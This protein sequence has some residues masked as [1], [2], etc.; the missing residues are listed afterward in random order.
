MSAD[1]TT[2]PMAATTDGVINHALNKSIA[3]RNSHAITG[4]NQSDSGIFGA[5]GKFLAA[6]GSTED[7]PIHVR[8]IPP[9]GSSGLHTVKLVTTRRRL[10][11]DYDTQHGLL[12][13]NETHGLYF[14]VN[15]G[16]DSG[17]D[18]TRFTA[19][20]VENDEASI[21]DQQRLLDAAPVQPSIRVVTRKSVHA[22]WLIEGDCTA[23]EWRIMQ[24]R[25]IEYFDGDRAITDPS[26]VM[27]LPFFDH[28]SLNT[29]SGVTQRKQV[30]LCT[31][32]PGRLHMLEQMRA[33][34]PEVG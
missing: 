16:G 9:K 30:E 5:L 24:Q 19:F 27:R 31:L 32:E 25:L 26:R 18:I 22:Y 1:M 34:F 12:A 11:T 33:A 13:L 29:E 10:T 14:V 20:F 6:F 15:E 23:D 3:F 4:D 28:L 8:A 21:E 7:T 2:P 17:R